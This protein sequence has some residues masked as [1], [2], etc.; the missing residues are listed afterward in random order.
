[1]SFNHYYLKKVAKN[2][3]LQARILALMPFH[4]NS[5]NKIKNS[6]FNTVYAIIF[7][8][9]V[10]YF[11]IQSI[12]VY[13]NSIIYAENDSLNGITTKSM[14]YSNIFVFICI[15]LLQN[16]Y[17]RNIFRVL[18][19]IEKFN[20]KTKNIL[21]EI[22]TNYTKALII[23]CIKSLSMKFALILAAFTGMQNVFGS[24]FASII[25]ILPIIVI[26][27]ISNLFY[28]LNIIAKFYFTTFNKK[29]ENILYKIKLLKMN[30][31]ATLY[32]RI[33]IHC[34]LSDQ[35]DEIAILH[36]DLCDITNKCIDFYQIPVLLTILN[37]FS[38]LVAQ[39]GRFE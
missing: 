39:V 27:S 34:E 1:M 16:I 14:F 22:Q 2:I 7:N 26:Y 20:K 9:L 6:N 36:G 12:S 21:N 15:Y 35:I 4:I 23:Y 5:K 8:L 18:Q 32:E 37:I 10:V 38:S 33:K 24:L 13:K 17:K 28:G 29:M 11:Y 25:I 19:N 3:Y 31:N 30:K